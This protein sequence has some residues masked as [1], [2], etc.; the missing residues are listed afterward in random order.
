ME[1]RVSFS[2]QLKRYSR[3]MRSLPRPL[4]P[5]IPALRGVELMQEED[6]KYVA[7]WAGDDADERLR[8]A[9]R[10]G[11]IELHS[12]NPC[13]YS[14]FDVYRITAK[15]RR[16]RDEFRRYREEVIR[17]R[18]KDVSIPMGEFIERV[19]RGELLQV[20]DEWA[21]RDAERDNAGRIAAS[22]RGAA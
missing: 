11:L 3:Y 19:E 7:E 1:K 6:L 17:S 5:V 2:E 15:G 18:K 14:R 20:P 13:G 12:R 9:V 22:A 16:A 8:E 21:A 4:N 10:D